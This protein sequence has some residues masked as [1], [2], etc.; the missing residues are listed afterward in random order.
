MKIINPATEE[1]VK[2]VLED[3]KESVNMKFDLLRKEQPVWQKVE[4]SE[5]VKILNQFS[6]LLEKNIEH[7]AALL[8]SE[9]GKPLQQS[10]NEV[11]GARARVKW[12]TGNAEFVQ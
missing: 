12:L 7:L 4:L 10:R 3:S 2:E 1:I 5:R 9:V 11:N 6:D 8:T